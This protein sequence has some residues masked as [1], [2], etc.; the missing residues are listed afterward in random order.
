MTAEPD[1][2]EMFRSDAIGKQFDI[3]E[4]PHEA[5]GKYDQGAFNNRPLKERLEETRNMLAE[6]ELMAHSVDTFVGS[7]NSNL[8]RNVMLR[9]GAKRVADR[10]VRSV[11]IV[12]PARNLAQT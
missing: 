12:S 3:I 10:R 6:Q 11:D 7:F 2:L 1:A 5:K 8:A 4:L 9:G